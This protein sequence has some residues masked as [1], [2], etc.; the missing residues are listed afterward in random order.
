MSKF[1]EALGIMSFTIEGVKFE[2]KPKKGDFKRMLDI[3]N[4]SKEN[5]TN[6]IDL[7]QPYILELLGRDTSLLKEDRDDLE[8]FV[9]FNIHIF[10][11]EILIAYRLAN[12]KEMEKKEKE[13]IG[14]YE[15]EQESKN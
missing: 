10:L 5:K 7:F 3:L 9:E 8:I 15:N 13:V 14:Q 12:R 2:V 1:S 6:I 11:K 4:E